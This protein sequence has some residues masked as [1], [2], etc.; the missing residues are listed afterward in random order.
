MVRDSGDR[1]FQLS[2]IRKLFRLEVKAAGGVSQWA[3]HKGMGRVQV[4]KVLH[5]HRKLRLRIIHALGFKRVE[6][7]SDDEARK[8]LKGAIA[9]SGNQSEWARLNGINRT[10]LNQVMSGRRR[11]GKMVLRALGLAQVAGYRRRS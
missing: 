9:R 6:L 3:Q 4:S 5:G 8:F 1:L 10:T 2:E 11:P 7:P